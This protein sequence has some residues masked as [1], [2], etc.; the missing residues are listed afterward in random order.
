VKLNLRLLKSL[1]PDN[2]IQKTGRGD[3]PDSPAM[4]LAI[5]SLEGSGKPQGLPDHTD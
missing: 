5:A 4:P 3:L 1:N 2:K